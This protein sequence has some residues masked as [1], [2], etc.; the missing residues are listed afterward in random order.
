VPYSRKTYGC[1]IPARLAISSV[2]APSRPPIAN[3][4]DCG[5]QDR[6]ATLGCGVPWLG[7]DPTH[8][9][10]RLTVP[11]AGRNGESAGALLPCRHLL[12][13]YTRARE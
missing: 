9:E 7:S 11:A 6:L 4:G 5:L 10:V 3:S 2:E 13:K 8:P 12:E 1:D